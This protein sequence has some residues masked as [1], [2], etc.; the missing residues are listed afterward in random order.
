MKKLFFLLVLMGATGLFGLV[1][2]DIPNPRSQNAWVSADTSVIPAKAQAR[3]N[4]LLDSLEKETGIEFAVVAMDDLPV[5]N[6]KGFAHRLFNQWRIGKREKNNGLLFIMGV[7][8]RKW[9]FET[10]Y[11]L[12]A[13]LPDSAQGSIAR[14]KMIPAFKKGDY[15]GGILTGVTEIVRH[16]KATDPN[17]IGAKAPEQEPSRKTRKPASDSI[18]LY[19][20]WILKYF[21]LALYVAGV[22]AVF[23]LMKK[24]NSVEKVNKLDFLYQIIMIL[25]M[26]FL[27]FFFPTR[28][29]VIFLG[30]FWAYVMNFFANLG[31]AIYIWREWDHFNR[32]P[33]KIRAH[34][35]FFYAY[36]AVNSLYPFF[37]LLGKVDTFNSPSFLWPLAAIIL[38]LAHI[39]VYMILRK[40]IRYGKHEC[41]HCG[42]PMR[43]IGE[44]ED[45]TFLKSGQ[46]TEEEIKSVD[47]DVW[48]CEKCENIRID[49]YLKAGK[50]SKCPKCGF[51][52]YY[53]EGSVTITAPTYTSTGEGKKT[54]RCS[55]C[56]HEHVEYYTIPVKTR[57]SSSSSSG[58][59]FGGGG[60]SG[61][62]GGSFGGGSS[63]GGG[64]SGGW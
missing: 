42:S 35:L 25:G 20:V 63:G 64:A 5:S 38:W 62:G 54:Y 37:W 2:T 40:K 50:Y 1:P 52:T 22:G 59:S 13:V 29:W 58:S 26:N 46:V 6:M 11:G 30:Y 47:Y 43:L 18:W 28:I 56:K 49:P 60:F 55:H 16:L 57:S 3:L 4:E 44:K 36:L 61:G 33:A 14:T 7:R 32:S 39:P 17:E 10:G 9:A 53:Y 27:L 31:Y 23:F 41:N 12:E 21:S 51:L 8:Q 48:F 45:D 15:A 24:P 19:L 34:Y